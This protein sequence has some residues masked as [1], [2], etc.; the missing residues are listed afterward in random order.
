[1]QFTFA[2][3]RAVPSQQTTGAE[4]LGKEAELYNS[5]F[6]RGLISG[7]LVTEIF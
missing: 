4:M 7:L 3:A 2:V 6:T 1:M 5:I